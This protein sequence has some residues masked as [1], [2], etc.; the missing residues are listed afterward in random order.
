MAKPTSNPQAGGSTSLLPPHMGHSQALLPLK[1]LPVGE[2][3]RST[4]ILFQKGHFGGKGCTQLKATCA[5][6][7]GFRQLPAKLMLPSPPSCSLASSTCCLCHIPD[8]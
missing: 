8:L 2:V 7:G 3:R 1:L 6:T 5:S 4:K